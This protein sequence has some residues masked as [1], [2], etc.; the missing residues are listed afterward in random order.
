MVPKN[1]DVGL[2]VSGVPPLGRRTEGG[3]QQA[4]NSSGFVFKTVLDRNGKGESLTR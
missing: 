2:I 3:G 4:G 1:E